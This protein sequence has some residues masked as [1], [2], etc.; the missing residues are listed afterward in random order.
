MNSF[1]LSEMIGIARSI[2]SIKIRFRVDIRKMILRIS[3]GDFSIF[4]I[5]RRFMNFYL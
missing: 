1:L 4:W 2:I 5:E 3:I